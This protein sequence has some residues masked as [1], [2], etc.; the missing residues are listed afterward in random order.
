[1]TVDRMRNFPLV[2][3]FPYV[4]QGLALVKVTYPRQCV[5]YPEKGFNSTRPQ[6]IQ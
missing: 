2:V 1:M 6:V 5:S 3:L 4:S